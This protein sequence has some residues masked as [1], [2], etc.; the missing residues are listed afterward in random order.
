M[1]NFPPRW[2]RSNFWS[3]DTCCQSYNTEK[4]IWRLCFTEEGKPEQM[5][6][7][8]R[9]SG[10]V[11]LGQEE[12]ICPSSYPRVGS[13]PVWTSVLLRI[14]R[15]GWCGVTGVRDVQEG[16]GSVCERT[17]AKGP[18]S[19]GQRRLLG[20]SGNS[21]RAYFRTAQPQGSTWAEPTPSWGLLRENSRVVTPKLAASPES[22]GERQGELHL[23]VSACF[24]KAMFPII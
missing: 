12:K 21:H 13:K 8:W 9:G 24:K 23:S 16:V 1:C 4:R 10:E 2:G 18:P 5:K 17:Q 22:Q 19:P 3:F 7:G 6:G 14:S 20:P 11:P 15:C